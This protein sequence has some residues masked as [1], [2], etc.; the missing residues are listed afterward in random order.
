MN[1]YGILRTHMNLYVF[2]VQYVV[3][4][5]YIVRKYGERKMNTL[6]YV[7]KFIIMFLSSFPWK[8]DAESLQFFLFILHKIKFYR[9]YWKSWLWKTMIF[10]G[11]SIIFSFDEMRIATGI[12]LIL[13]LILKKSEIPTKKRFHFFFG[14]LIFHRVY[15]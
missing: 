14:T 1:T 9:F 6:C 13:E 2:F 11:F 10:N 8:I 7:S 4:F 15:D 5:R 3:H 12:W